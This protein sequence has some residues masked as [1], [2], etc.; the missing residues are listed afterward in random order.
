MMR[1]LER[2]GFTVLH[3]GDNDWREYAAGGFQ[4]NW[5]HRLTPGYIHH[6]HRQLGDMVRVVV[7]DPG[8]ESHKGTF[9]QY[10]KSASR[11]DGIPAWKVSGNIEKR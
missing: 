3:G 6:L 10:Q 9:E 11:P 5:K 1:S 2:Q 7:A 8:E 4:A